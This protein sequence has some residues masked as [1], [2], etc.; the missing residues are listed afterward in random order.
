[1]NYY[2]GEIDAAIESHRKAVQMEPNDHLKRSNLGDAL[3]VAGRHE[4]A[5][6]S[7]RQAQ[8]LALAALNVN[9]GDANIKLDLAWINAMLGETDAAR[10]LIDNAREQSPDDPYVDFINAL[11]WQRNGDSDKALAA[12]RDAIQK[13]YSK[14]LIAAEPHLEELRQDPRF[15][16]LM[17]I[18]KNP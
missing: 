9:P 11:I 10:R 6:E 5:L 8:S 18:S 3:W 14:I 12:V 13:G 15:N 2:L 17:S 7:Y 16:E 4:A 1:M